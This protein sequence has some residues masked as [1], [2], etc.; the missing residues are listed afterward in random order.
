[1]LPLAPWALLLGSWSLQ[2]ETN[3]KRVFLR[4]KADWA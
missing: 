2:P 4:E 3:S 1:M